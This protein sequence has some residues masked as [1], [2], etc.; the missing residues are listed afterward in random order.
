MPARNRRNLIALAVA[1]VVAAAAL[2]WWKWRQPATP[3]TSVAECLRMARREIA[4]GNYKAAEN[5]CKQALEQEPESASVLLLAGEAAMKDKRFEDA[6]GYFLAVPRSDGDDSIT[7]SLS[8]GEV[9]RAMGHLAVAER[10]YRAVLSRRPSHLIA[11]ERLAFILDLQGRR[12]ESAP[13]LFEVLRR[14]RISYSTLIRLLS[15]D[16]A[17]P[18][19]DQLELVRKAAQD[20]AAVK[21]ADAVNLLAA[22]RSDEAEPLLREAVRLDPNLI[23]AHARL[24]LL[25]LDRDVS[26]V[27]DWERRLPRQAGEHPDVWVVRGLWCRRA[28]QLR[29]AIRCFWEAATRDPNQRVA[30]Y[31]LGQLLTSPEFVNDAIAC[32]ARARLLQ[33]LA[34]L[35]N[36]LSDHRTDTS[37][38]L[39]ASKVLE[40]LG[41]YWEAYGWC[42]L[43]LVT[44]P[45]QDSV[46]M[47]MRKLHARLSPT[48]SWTDPKSDPAVNMDCS[49]FPLPHWPAAKIKSGTSSPAPMSGARFRFV[50][51]AAETGLSFTYYNNHPAKSA[52]TRMHEFSGGGIGVLD[53]DGDGSPDVYLTQGCPWP[54]KVESTV[55]RDRLFHNA[56]GRFLDVTER[57]GLGDGWFSQGVAV[58]DVDNDGFPDLYLANIGR[59]RLYLNNGDGTFREITDQA[60]ITGRQWTTSCLI[61]DLNGDGFPDLYDVNYVKGDDVFDRLCLNKGRRRACAP[62]A[63]P[64]ERDRIYLNRGDGRFEELTGKS[65]DPLEPARPGLGIVA[66]DLDGSGRLSLFVANDAVANALLANKTARNGPLKLEEHALRAGVAFDRD[67]RA[68]A[69]MGV[70]AGD[71]DGNGLIDFFVTNYFEEGNSLYLQT[72]PGQFEEVSRPT[73]LYGPS[74]RQLGFGTQFLDAD[75]DG[76]LDLVVAN[77]HLDDFRY[78]GIPFRMRPQFFVGRRTGPGFQLM[79]PKDVGPYFDRKLLGRSLAVLDWNRDGCPDFIVTHLETPV[80]L[81]T[82]ETLRHGHWL[83]IRLYGVTSSRDAIGTTV[84]AQWNGRTFTHQLTAGSGY[85]ASNERML[86][87]GLGDCQRIAKLTV[88]WPSGARQTFANV[89]ADRELAISEGISE[90]IELPSAAR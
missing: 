73:G 41:R 50:D 82:N 79:A 25:I 36:R 61:A 70:A 37:A 46:R 64:A 54:P 17:I 22:H 44:D 47:R 86:L 35:A 38:M 39:S 71:V 90:P 24:G 65:A 32:A 62:G 60:G 69:C 56:G 83:K 6:L 3:T 85:Q 13:H 88:R 45:R 21:L 49:R 8:A 10:E 40:E 23:E 16:A 11:R 87:F 28:G 76:Q 77:G 2:G 26:Q 20:P 34:V 30:C 74:F 29:A 9:S 15:R 89:K 14:D 67:G 75:L 19:P 58:G 4:A 68:Q 5:Y 78:L 63:F 12:W 55:H 1:V 81:V 66:A 52:G 33:K 18:F 7:A 80:A 57:V 43:I 53:F 27:P 31:Q 72:A 59:N 51:R 48:L 84:Q 42:G